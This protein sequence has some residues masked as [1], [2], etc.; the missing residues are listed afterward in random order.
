MEKMKKTI[1]SSDRVCTE[2]GCIANSYGNCRHH[3]HEVRISDKKCI[4]KQTKRS[5]K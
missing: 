2:F 1:N 4:D 5:I 3:I